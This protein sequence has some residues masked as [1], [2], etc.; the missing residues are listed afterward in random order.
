MARCLV[1]CGSNLGNRRELL[2]RAVELL[3]F[4]PGVRILATS[5]YRE[6]RPVGGPNG[7]TPFL[8]AACLLET[9]LG[10]NELLGMLKAVENTLERQREIRWGPRTI[11]L[12]LLLYGDV[13]VNSEE[14][15]LPHPRMSTRRFVLEPCVEIAAEFRHP[16][17]GCSVGD[18]LE[19][20]SPRHP[21]VAVVGVPGA[22]APEV[23][24][25]IAD[26]TL[27]RLLHTPSP[28]P[29]LSPIAGKGG[30]RGAARL[31][32][33]FCDT[34]DGWSQPIL[35]EGWP[36]D[37]HG[38]IAEYWIGTLMAMAELTLA[39]DDVTE[40]EG[41]YRR[42]TDSTVQPNVVI[43]LTTP[44]DVLA[45]RISFRSGQRSEFTDVFAD[46]ERFVSPGTDF[47]RRRFSRDLS[48]RVAEP[49]PGPAVDMSS[50]DATVAAAARFLAT[51]QERLVACLCDGSSNLRAGMPCGVVKIP[52][53]DIGE[54]AEQAVAAVEAMG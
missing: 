22:G 14:L 45:D 54:A 30:A 39:A 52:S 33:D 10:P 20:I 24:A 12:D 9:D 42:L 34:L 5:R 4:M 25:A 7:Q 38:T 43:L 35:R 48:G 27:G 40:L 44:S 8:N 36:T 50:S 6:F 28:L 26:F 47:G 53:D 13:V 19:N 18:L 15:V 46:L 3:R 11:D 17:A 16:V 21:H 29:S 51:L 1:G 37:P 41:R 49:A 31:L 32:A 2:D 23:A